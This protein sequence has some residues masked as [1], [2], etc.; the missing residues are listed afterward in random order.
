MI[1]WTGFSSITVSRYL[2]EFRKSGLIG[3]A[4]G[5]IFLSDLGNE[6]FN[7]LGD[8]FQKEISI[9]QQIS[10]NTEIIE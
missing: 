5:I 1:R 2:Q 8:L 4:P 10:C 3:H 6:I 9:A 7:S